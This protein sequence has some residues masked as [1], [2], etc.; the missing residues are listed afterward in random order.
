MIA[1]IA[2]NTWI[3]GKCE[4]PKMPKIVTLSRLPDLTIMPFL[5]TYPILRGLSTFD[6][7]SKFLRLL[8][9]PILR[10]NVDFAETC[11]VADFAETAH[12]AGKVYLTETSESAE[13]GK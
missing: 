6:G 2:K 3:A 5:P 12:F 1:E 9:L 8:I 7:I 13:S 10:E 11:E 4:T